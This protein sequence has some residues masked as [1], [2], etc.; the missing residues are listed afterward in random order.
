MKSFDATDS[1]TDSHGVPAVQP[2]IVITHESLPTTQP[3]E[4]SWFREAPAPAE[5]APES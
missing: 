4:I 3:I 1:H 2:T 5:M